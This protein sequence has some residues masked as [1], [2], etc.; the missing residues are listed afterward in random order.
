MLL[1]ARHNLDDL[2]SLLRVKIMMTNFVINQPSEFSQ[3]VSPIQ[4]LNQ[5]RRLH[6]KYSSVE[7]VLGLGIWVINIKPFQFAHQKS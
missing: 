5:P 7:C 2:V 4:I 3:I 6:Q 1:L